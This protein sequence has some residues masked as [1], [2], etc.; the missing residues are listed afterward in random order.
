[1][2]AQS[3]GEGEIQYAL[4]HGS[5]SL[6]KC[7]ITTVLWLQ[8]GS[9]T[10]EIRCNEGSCTNS[11]ISVYICV[12]RQRSCCRTVRR[13]KNREGLTCA[14]CLD[15]YPHICRPCGHSLWAVSPYHHQQPTHEH[16]LFTVLISHISFNKGEWLTSFSPSWFWIWWETGLWNS[17][18][19]KKVSGNIHLQSSTKWLRPSSPKCIAPTSR[20]LKVLHAQSG[21]CPSLGKAS[22]TF[23]VRKH[24][25]VLFL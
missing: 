18:E 14:V 2:T 12:P 17:A 1:M 6:N 21:L 7:V 8:C 10:Q 15:I 11:G 22:A 24:F 19:F 4:I 9:C 5:A 23:G 25:H 20:T 13:K 3:A 16:S